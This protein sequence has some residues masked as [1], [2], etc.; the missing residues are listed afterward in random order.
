MTTLRE[1][2][3]ALAELAI[4]GSTVE[5]YRA[6]WLMY[7]IKNDMGLSELIEAERDRIRLEARLRSE[8]RA[9]RPLWSKLLHLF[10]G[11]S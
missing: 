5:K 11:A 7:E 3:L 4:T 1:D 10:R 8:Q 9:A 2:Y 6:E